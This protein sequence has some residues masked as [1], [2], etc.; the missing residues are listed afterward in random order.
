LEDGFKYSIW[1]SPYYLV[2]TCKSW[3]FRSYH[4]LI[5][6]KCHKWRQRFVYD[7]HCLLL[8]IYK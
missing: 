8:I 2:L 1:E 3:G 7:S 6:F 4:I 5:V